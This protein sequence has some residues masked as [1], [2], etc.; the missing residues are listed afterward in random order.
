MVPNVPRS[1]LLIS[2]SALLFR[3]LSSKFCQF[4]AI[5][6]SG[7]DTFSFQAVFDASFCPLDR[8]VEI[9]GWFACPASE[10]LGAYILWPFT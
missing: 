10:D 3:D 6:Q 1:L 5:A 4:Q 7:P 8:N 2:L 9:L